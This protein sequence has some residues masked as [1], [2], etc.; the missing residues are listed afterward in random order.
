MQQQGENA[1]IHTK[2]HLEAGMNMFLCSLEHVDANRPTIGSLS[3]MLLVVF[4]QPMQEGFVCI[5][6]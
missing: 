2:I 4:N 5:N 1:H 3:K 6:A